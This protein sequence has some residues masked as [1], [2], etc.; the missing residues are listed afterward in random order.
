[1]VYY[2]HFRKGCH[3]SFV[4][5]DASDFESL[6]LSLNVAYN[7][8]SYFNAGSS[9]GDMGRSHLDEVTQVTYSAQ[10]EE[11]VVN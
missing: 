1:M 2:L 11:Q 8:F 10:L 5:V 3:G 4:R 6:L 9:V 7:F